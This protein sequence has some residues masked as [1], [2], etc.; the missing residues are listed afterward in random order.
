MS[1]ELSFNNE[2]G[3]YEKKKSFGSRVKG[4]LHSIQ[5]A[6]RE[7]QDFKKDVQ[8]QGKIA[9]RNA[10]KQGYIAGKAKK[11]H[12]KGKEDAQRTFGGKFGRLEGAARFAQKHIEVGGR[13]EDFGFGGGSSGL[14]A[15][16]FSIRAPTGGEDFGF[17]GSPGKKG[18]KRDRFADLGF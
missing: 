15:D 18:K 14:S 16:D 3:Q 6:R 8:R 9:E 5:E 11:A 2:T 13:A 4:K 7:Q 10:Y 17:G 1:E 12:R